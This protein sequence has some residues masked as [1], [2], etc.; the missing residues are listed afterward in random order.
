MRLNLYPLFPACGVLVAAGAL[1]AQTP[2]PATAARTVID[3]ATGKPI[4]GLPPKPVEGPSVRISGTVRESETGLPIG[5][6]RVLLQLGRMSIFPDRVVPGQAGTTTVISTPDGTF[7]FDDVPPGPC[8]VTATAEG[9]LPGADLPKWLTVRK[10]QTVEIQLIKPAVISGRIVDSETNKPVSGIRVVAWKASYQF[11][12]FTQGSDSEDVISDKD[13]A[14]QIEKVI[15]GP[16]FLEM[17]A[18]EAEEQIL[19]G[20]DATT[21]PEDDSPK[22]GYRRQWWPGDGATF[23]QP[24]IARGGSA[25]NFADVAIARKPMFN[26]TGEVKTAGCAPQRTVEINVSQQYGQSVTSRGDAVTVSCGARFLVANL[27]PGEYYISTDARPYRQM[28]NALAKVAIADRN[29]KQDLYL[30]PPLDVKGTIELPDGFPRNHPRLFFRVA[31]ID[32]PSVGEARGFATEGST[33]GLIGPYPETVQLQISGLPAPYYVSEIQYA[34]QPV[35]DGIV[36][37]NPLATAQTITVR[38]SAKSATIQG[39][40]KANGD[41]VASAKVI[42]VPWPLRWKGSFPIFFDTSAIDGSFTIAQLPPDTYHVLSVETNAWE[43]ELQKPGVL[44]ALA[45]QGTEVTAAEGQTANATLELKRVV[46][47]P[48]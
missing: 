26:V 43:T 44:A 12:R 19:T 41:P 14:F 38:V 23:A 31:F 32:S 17:V 39:T 35:H 18:P 7:S 37:L 33:F 2:K 10:P 34:G 30:A 11:G 29:L 36:A 47:A 8:S 27:S 25:P 24:F 20:D 5:G 13:G 40:V 45:A 1:I 9:Y 16:Y 42:L 15:P 28:P 6:A 46:I 48:W 3:P 22:L 4:P 21:N